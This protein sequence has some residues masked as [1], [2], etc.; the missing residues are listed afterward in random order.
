MEAGGL[1]SG[2]HYNAG[3]PDDSLLALSCLLLTR[4]D[5]QPH[6]FSGISSDDS[7]LALSCLLLT[8]QEENK[9]SCASSVN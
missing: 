1:G 4:Q 2:Y 7:L 5:N 9:L 3:S 6:D 8:R